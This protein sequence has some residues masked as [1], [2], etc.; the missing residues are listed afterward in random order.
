MLHLEK[1]T[2]KDLDTISKLARVIWND[3]YVP[4]I[5]QKQ[6]DYMLDKIYSLQSLTEQL[7]EKKHRMYLIR[8]DEKSIGFVSVSLEKESNYFLHKFYI[9][10]RQ[11][12]T[13]IGTKVLDLLIEIIRPKLLTLTV[14]RQNFKSINF[15][16]KNGFKIDRVEDFDIGNGYL[17]NDFV[18]VKH[19]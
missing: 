12:N 13:G 1:A 8:S 7:T 5:G 9:D 10:Q 19:F 15:Y 4:I 11:S 14:N 18:M 3:H 17:M 16:F 2:E 6:V